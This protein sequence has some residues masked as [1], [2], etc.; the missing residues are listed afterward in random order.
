VIETAWNVRQ[1]V[2]VGPSGCRVL[3]GRFYGTSYRFEEQRVRPVAAGTR[4]EV[5]NA[6]GSVHLR[7]GAPGKV[8][9]SLAKVVFLP[10]EERAREFAERVKLVERES[11]G[12][13]RLATNRDE[14]QRGV[15][16][17]LET[18]LSI[19]VPPDTAVAVTNQHGE[20]SVEDVARAEVESSFDHLR[21]ER[22]AGDATLKSR[23]GDVTV[24]A[25][26]GA[27]KLHSRHGRVEIRDVAGRVELDSEHGDVEAQDTGGLEA[28]VAR[29]H[30]AATRVRGD[31]EVRGEH[32]EL[33]AAEVTGSA[34]LSTSFSSVEVHVVGGDAQLQ[35]EHGQ[36]EAQDVKGALTVKASFDTVKLERIGGPVEIEVEHG[37]LVAR[38]L[39]RGV[40]A[41]VSGDSVEIADFEGPAEVRVERGSVELAPGRAVVDPYLVISSHG[42]IRL[43]VPA[44]SRFELDAEVER[45]EIDI[46]LPGIEAREKTARAF[47]GTL[48]GGGSRVRLRAEGGDVSVFGRSA[49]VSRE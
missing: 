48:G 35:A 43:D 2:G 24:A 28:K 40:K 32:S 34:R 10:T 36:V 13:L 5:D 1:H 37:G 4:I 15:D 20:V 27:L 11:G 39:G 14:I 42:G 44:E 8:T 41:K 18:H 19:E 38:T 47:K 7:A 29:G 16:V 49:V 45:G 3:G 12:A 33:K 9:V 23:H 30:F 6:F 31:L 25:V 26:G 46:E 22:V 21:V 17:G